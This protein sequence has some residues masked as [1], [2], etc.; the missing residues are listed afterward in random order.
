MVS[1]AVNVNGR[2]AADSA[3]TTAKKTVD[4]VGKFSDIMAK[5]MSAG[6]GA[7]S[8]KSSVKDVGIQQTKKQEYEPDSVTDDVKTDDDCAIS[9]D[10]KDTTES[11]DVS[12]DKALNVAEKVF[13]KISDALDMSEEELKECMEVLGLSLMDLLQ[14]GNILKLVVETTGTQ[15][16]MAI[17]TDEGLSEAL[18]NIL[19]YVKELADGMGNMH[20]ASEESGVADS[21]IEDLSTSETQVEGES[22]EDVIASKIVTDSE[23][24]DTTYKALN[25]GNNSGDGSDMANQGKPETD[26]VKASDNSKTG[27][28]S[29]SVVSQLTGTFEAALDSQAQGV[30][31]AD[32]V[33]QVVD[34][35]KF[36]NTQALKSIE[37]AL[38]PENL[39][40]VNIVVSVREGVV[41]A[42]IVTENEQVKK[43]LEN[44]VNTL[45]ETLENQGVKV[46]SVEVTVQTHE[47]ENNQQF[48]DE[49][50][51]D[52]SSKVRKKIKL[53]D[54][55]FDEEEDSQ[56]EE[57]IVAHENSSVEYMA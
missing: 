1:S 2:I 4:T 47:F 5:S 56:K 46:E 33:R 32:V 51:S 10:I 18:K 15:D 21:L 22:L 35:I 44:Q 13:D 6:F 9:K 38:N 29:E 12:E 53:D 34:S 30:D 52:N 55:N 24:T 40:K 50:N 11:Q 49:R 42:H 19:D 27:D 31:A 7:D 45:K 8:G 54:I 16:T 14:P 3:Y 28:V 25:T 41:M 57:Q 43:A 48:N 26:D 17:V 37:V 23:S 39:G 36:N 20:T